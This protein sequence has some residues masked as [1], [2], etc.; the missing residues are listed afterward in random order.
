LEP[1]RRSDARARG[2]FS[3]EDARVFASSTFRERSGSI[4]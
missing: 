4:D 1:P 2:I 3:G